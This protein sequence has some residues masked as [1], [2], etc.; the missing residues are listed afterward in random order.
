MD[1]TQQ[2]YMIALA[3]SGSVSKAAKNLGVSQPA[4]SAWL[5]NIEDQL[6]TKLMHRT[7]NKL[8]LTP[9]GEI[10]LR[11]S[12]QMIELRDKTYA[13]IRTIAGQEKEP[14][15]ITGTPNG[16]ADLFARM[17][18]QLSSDFPG[19]E[20]RFIESYNQGSID[21]VKSG[22]AD[23]AIGSACALDDEYINYIAIRQRKLILAVPYGLPSAYDS[24][25]VKNGD[26]LPKADM[27]ALIGQPFIMPNEEMSYHKAL[28]DWLSAKGYE[29][30]VVFSSA[31]TRSIYNM[32]R[33]GN[34]I[35]VVPRNFFSPLDRVSPL[36]LDPDILS[37]SV[38][39]Y[40]KDR[41]LSP[42]LAAFIEATERFLVAFTR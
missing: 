11:A 4:I 13:E 29:P 24:S 20:F 7:K 28:I 9:A 18:H 14:I 5:K 12:R 33:I 30:N 34:G 22:E 27:S 3:E 35:G 25:H 38:L 26:E 37:Y 41:A 32:I 23:I 16:G 21:L 40:K 8:V 15:V 39:M 10:Y 6:G 36:E 31:S 1:V 19:L 2:R 17:Y 42:E